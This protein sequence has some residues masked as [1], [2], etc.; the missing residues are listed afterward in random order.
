MGLH[1][2]GC[3]A[4]ARRGSLRCPMGM[5]PGA[6]PRGGQ[7]LVAVTGAAD[8]GLYTSDSNIRGDCVLA[9][10][11]AVS[12]AHRSVTCC[13]A[14]AVGKARRRASLTLPYERS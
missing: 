9:S 10:G 13:A 4:G 6:A 12:V 5:V 2:G 7:G 3:N 11:F 1:H 8:R 14:A